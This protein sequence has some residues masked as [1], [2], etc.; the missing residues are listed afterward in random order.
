MLRPPRLLQSTNSILDSSGLHPRNRPNYGVTTSCYLEAPGS[1]T[2]L[3]RE[4]HLPLLHLVAPRT[5]KE[6]SLYDDSHSKLRILLLP[7]YL[8][9]LVQLP[10]GQLLS[11]LLRT[12]LVSTTEVRQELTGCPG[13]HNAHLE[14]WQHPTVPCA[15]CSS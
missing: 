2:G 5:V 15:P 13:H 8:L 14:L 10:V 3:R 12:S 11:S 4:Q 9:S 7:F 1:S 6:S